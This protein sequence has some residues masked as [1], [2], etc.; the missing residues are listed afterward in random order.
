MK[1]F[2]FKKGLLAVG[3]AAALGST[4]T[5]AD[6]N[7]DSIY[8]SGLQSSDAKVQFDVTA[9]VAAV[10]QIALGDASDLD[11]Q[12]YDPLHPEQTDAFVN[13]VCLYS[14]T[15]GVIVHAE[16]TNPDD[17]GDGSLVKELGGTPDDFISYQFRLLEGADGSTGS[18]PQTLI[19]SGG[20]DVTLSPGSNSSV[21]TIP[22]DGTSTTRLASFEVAAEQTHPILPTYGDYRDTIK[23]TV[24]PAF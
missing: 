21:S 10:V 6:N 17:G 19:G 5:L 7:P 13:N 2:H 15:G 18:N 16:S 14:N 20:G 23:I 9:R 11:L 4:T 22:C 12:T 1:T 24:N 8:D 3:L